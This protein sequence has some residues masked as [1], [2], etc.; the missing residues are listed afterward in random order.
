M[1][2]GRRRVSWELLAVS[3]VGCLSG[4]G[5]HRLTALVFSGRAQPLM[6]R[7]KCV[8]LTVQHIGGCQGYRVKSI[9]KGLESEPKVTKGM[10]TVCPQ[11]GFAACFLVCV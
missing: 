8:V 6:P 5:K 11:P 4:A 1:V 2:V 9:C 3:R 10:V 7:S